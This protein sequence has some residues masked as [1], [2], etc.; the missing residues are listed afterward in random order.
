V[1]FDETLFPFTEPFCTTR[2]DDFEFLDVVSTDVPARIGPT[3]FPLSAGPLGTTTAQPRAAPGASVSGGASVPPSLTG[4]LPTGA[5][6]G[7]TIHRAA[8]PV[9][10]SSPTHC[11]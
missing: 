11:S 9:V 7:A 8:A 1:S 6:L 3:Q 4:P 10:P 2:A 5:R